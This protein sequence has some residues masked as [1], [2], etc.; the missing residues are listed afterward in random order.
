LAWPFFGE[1]KVLVQLSGELPENQA[2]LYEA[3]LEEVAG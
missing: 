1:G 3:V 2:S